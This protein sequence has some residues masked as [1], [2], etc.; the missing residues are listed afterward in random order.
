MKPPLKHQRSVRTAISTMMLLIIILCYGGNESLAG[1]FSLCSSVQDCIDNEIDYLMIVAAV[2]EDDEDSTTIFNPLVDSLAEHWADFLDLNVGIVGTENINPLLPDSIRGFVQN[3]YESNSAAHVND[4]HLGFVLLIGDWK[5]DDNS[6]YMIPTKKYL[7]EAEQYHGDHFYACVTY[8]SS[9]DTCDDFPDLL[10]GRLSVGTAQ[11]SSSGDF[12]ELSSV[13]EKTV[14]YSTTSRDGWGDDILLVSSDSNAAVSYGKYLD[15][16]KTIIP[17]NYTIDEIRGWESPWN[18]NASLIRQDI[19]S[20]INEGRWI[21]DGL[22]HG[23]PLHWKNR[24]GDQGAGILRVTDL[25][26]LTN[27]DMYPVIFALSCQTGSFTGQ[28]DCMAEEY[29]NADT[30]GAIA[31]FGADQLADYNQSKILFKSIHKAIF[32]DNAYFMGEMIAD[33][34]IAYLGKQSGSTNEAHNYNLFGD[35][36]V[37][38]MWVEEDSTNLPDLV[39]SQSSMTLTPPYPNVGDSITLSAVVGNKGPVDADTFHVQFYREHPDTGGVAIGAK[40]C[41]PALLAWFDADTF[42]V[43]ICTDTTDLGKNKIYAIA[44]CDSEVTEIY[45]NNN[46]SW[47][48]GSVYLY[49]ENFPD[50]V[51]LITMSNPAVIDVV[52]DSNLDFLIAGNCWDYDGLAWSFSRGQEE[53]ELLSSPAVGDLDNDGNQEV[54]LS[55]VRRPQ[56]GFEIDT[57]FVYQQDSLDYY[58]TFNCDSVTI[59]GSVSLA[60]LDSDDTLD[61]VFGLAARYDVQD[62]NK[63]VALHVVNDSLDVLWQKAVNGD[64]TG[65]AICSSP[66]IGDIDSDGKPEVVVLSDNGYIYALNGESGDTSW[67]RQIGG[68]ASSQASRSCP[69]LADVDE[70]G[71][72]EIIARTN[73][74]YLAVLKGENGEDNTGLRYYLGS[75]LSDKSRSP[76]VGDV[77]GDGHLEINFSG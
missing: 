46:A 69:V 52:D 34:K 71:K 37:N 4:G 11:D 30:C 50:T 42:D 5:D 1:Q 10:I 64:S 27:R 68:D 28:T 12:I 72:L 73:E 44:D 24:S 65:G 14:L 18:L 35:P 57:L 75:D 53:F 48:W 9:P 25:D 23:T 67:T 32:K 39:I 63:V 2:L 7:G 56:Q 31:Y 21:V 76:C 15:T 33:G 77:D 3:V 19:I 17:D 58:W 6:A 22:A 62:S 16:L 45:E 8:E 38:I 74:D 54:V 20:R 51:D 41:I 61:I 66:A 43:T 49:Q 40:Q 29:V 59:Y 13:V 47:K 70:D 36:A 26:D 55:C 60:Y